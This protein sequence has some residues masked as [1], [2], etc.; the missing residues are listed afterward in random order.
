MDLERLEQLIETLRKGDLDARE[1]ARR[2]QDSLYEDIGY[3]RV[4]HA[5]A[6]RQGFPEVVF[7]KGKPRS[8]VVGI[9]ERLLKNSNSNL[10]VT[11]TDADTFGEIRNI[12]TGAEWH[13]AA[14]L[15]RVMRDTAELG[16]GSIAVVTAG[17]RDNSF[18]EGGG[19]NAQ[20]KGKRCGSSLGG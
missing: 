19:L 7:G 18:W 20:T 4:D 14:R 1:A 16:I 9:V 5:R 15:I 8:Y 17:T 6:A 11:H 3:A 13:E 12:V 2:I 10:I